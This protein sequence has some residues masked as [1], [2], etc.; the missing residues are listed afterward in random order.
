[1]AVNIT[2]KRYFYS[3]L[4]RPSISDRFKEIYIAKIKGKRWKSG[5]MEKINTII[6]K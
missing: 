4:L 5:L 3:E 2:F 6:D 1:M